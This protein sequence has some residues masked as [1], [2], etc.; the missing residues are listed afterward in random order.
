LLFRRKNIAT[1]NIFMIN[2]IDTRLFSH[3]I[4]LIN[5]YLIFIEL[6]ILIFLVSR[7]LSPFLSLSFYHIYSSTLAAS[8]RGGRKVNAVTRFPLDP[9]PRVPCFCTERALGL[10]PSRQ[11]LETS[12]L[13]K[14]PEN[15]IIGYRCA[16]VNCLRYPHR[17]FWATSRRLAVRIRQ[18]Y[19][20]MP[21]FVG[22]R[23]EARKIK[24]WWNV[25]D[26]RDNSTYRVRLRGSPR[27][28][29]NTKDAIVQGN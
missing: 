13:V 17:R 29:A 12:I 6:Y 8:L 24:R 7:I 20:K 16:V 4:I 23:S 9:T 5:H 28:R 2:I 10:F 11:A 15:A 1:R 22:L 27:P 26:T 25:A 14:W 21:I 3:V 19:V 18:F